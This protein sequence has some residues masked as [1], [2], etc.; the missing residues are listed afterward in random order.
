MTCSLQDL[1]IAMG[2]WSSLP[3]GNSPS[4]WLEKPSHVGEGHKWVLNKR[5]PRKGQVMVL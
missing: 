5:I 4:G 2:Y 3:V 1:M